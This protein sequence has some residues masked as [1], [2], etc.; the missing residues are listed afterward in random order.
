MSLIRKSTIPQRVKLSLTSLPDPC[1]HMAVRGNRTSIRRIQLAHSCSPTVASASLETKPKVGALKKQQLVP[2][3]E[4]GDND[5]ANGNDNS[6]DND[7]GIS[8]GKDNDLISLR[9]LLDLVGGKIRQTDIKFLRFLC[10]DHRI[11]YVPCRLIYRHSEMMRQRRTVEQPIKLQ[12]ISSTTLIRVIVWMHQQSEMEM[13]SAIGGKRCANND[14]TIGKCEMIASQWEKESKGDGNTN[15]KNN[16]ENRSEYTQNYGSSKKRKYATPPNKTNDKITIKKRKIANDQRC[17]G[18]HTSTNYNN[19]EKTS[20]VETAENMK[21]PMC[22]VCNNGGNGKTVRTLENIISET[23]EASE[24]ENETNECKEANSKNMHI[25]KSQN[26]QRANGSESGKVTISGNCEQDNS[27]EKLNENENTGCS[28][29][30]I[31]AKNT[32]ISNQNLTIDAKPGADLDAKKNVSGFGLSL[33]EERFLGSELCQL[34]ELILAAHCLGVDAL[35]SLA[36]NYLNELMAQSTRSELSTMLQ[37]ST[38]LAEVRR[39][40]ENHRPLITEI[41]SQ[42]DH[43]PKHHCSARKATNSVGFK[44]NTRRGKGHSIR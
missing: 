33:W 24:C 41:L 5:N 10:N 43:R 23:K 27:V 13:A 32:K 9:T 35:T 42:V 44:P 4:V 3:K 7:A 20:P 8:E 19:S 29:F 6:N 26:K 30:A 31:K 36:A 1:A 21:N 37:V 17:S 25:S 38:R 2:R 18:C 34:M 39:T 28:L 15:A 12:S 16:R 22:N 11:I 14:N 40:V